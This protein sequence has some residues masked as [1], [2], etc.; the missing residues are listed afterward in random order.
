MPKPPS[1]GWISHAVVCQTITPAVELRTLVLFL[2][3][4]QV[5][6][7]ITLAR[8]AASLRRKPLLHS[9]SITIQSRGE[10]RIK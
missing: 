8:L 6:P 2:H 9:V 5:L 4:S 10:R 7:G 1:C 3:S